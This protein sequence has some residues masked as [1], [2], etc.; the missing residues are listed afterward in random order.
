[1]KNKKYKYLIFVNTLRQTFSKMKKSFNLNPTKAVSERMKRVKRKGTLLESSMAKILKNLGIKYEFQP[2][3]FAHP[4]FRIKNTKILIFCDSS[5]WHG[6]RPRELNGKAF[7]RNKAFWVKKLNENKK[8][9]ASNNYKL[10]RSGWSVHRFWDTDV[11]TKI[12]KVERRIERIVE[13]H[14]KKKS[15][16]TA[17]GT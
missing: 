4:D 17:N 10:R 8:R 6:R 14:G 13:N 9:D 1:M 2:D 5:F 11:L 15:T 7:R 12:D 16:A 3:I